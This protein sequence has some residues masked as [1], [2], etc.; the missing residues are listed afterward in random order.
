MKTIKL[1]EESWKILQL[2]KLEL[3][4]KNLS[5]AILDQDNLHKAALNYI[6]VLTNDS[7]QK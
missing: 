6:G 4:S 7:K 3:K 5:Q 2:W 1:T